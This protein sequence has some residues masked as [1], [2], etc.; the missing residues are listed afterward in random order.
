MSDFS[1]AAGSAQTLDGNGLSRVNFDQGTSVGADFASTV[2]AYRARTNALDQGVN[3]II[4]GT[5]GEKANP[6]IRQLADLYSYAVETQLVIRTS[7]QLTT[8]IRQLMS[9]Q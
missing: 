4:E 7:T 8:G 1:L 5:G 3:Q 6:Q 2:E 9:G